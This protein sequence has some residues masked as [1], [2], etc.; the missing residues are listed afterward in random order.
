MLTLLSSGYGKPNWNVNG[1]CRQLARRTY[2]DI[3]VGIKLSNFQAI[4]GGL[5]MSLQS[6]AFTQ[7]SEDLR[8]HGLEAMEARENVPKLVRLLTL[9]IMR[10]FSIC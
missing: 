1:T 8:A 3:L 7:C 5:N 2:L 9:P 6:Y 10:H 4:S